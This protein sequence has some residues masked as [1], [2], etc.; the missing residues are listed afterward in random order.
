MAVRKGKVPPTQ[1]KK[2]KASDASVEDGARK[3]AK[4]L[5]VSPDSVAAVA[6]VA[7][8]VPHD[9]PGTKTLPAAPQSPSQPAVGR[10]LLC[11]RP[12]PVPQ[13]RLPWVLT[14]PGRKGPRRRWT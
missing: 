14:F 6:K 11:P 2:R 12:P 13:A 7:V 8:D 9:P 4:V 10:M 3:K 5:P 1:E